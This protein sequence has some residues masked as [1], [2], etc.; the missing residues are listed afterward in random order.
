MSKLAVGAAFAA[1]NYYK[2]KNE[3]D[4]ANRDNKDSKNK[5]EEHEY[6]GWGEDN[7]KLEMC[8]LKE[9]AYHDNP[10]LLEFFKEFDKYGSKIDD[11]DLENLAKEGNKMAEELRKKCEEQEKIRKKLEQMGI[12]FD[13]TYSDRI[14]RI[15]LFDTQEY[16]KGY[17]YSYTDPDSIN[18]F[19]MCNKFNGLVLTEEMLRTPD[20]SGFR[21]RYEKEKT[22]Y[23]NEMEEEKNLTK[24]LESNKR[25]AKFLVFKRKSLEEENARI[26]KRLEEINT[27]RVRTEEEKVRAETFEN[28]TEEQKRDLLEYIQL[29]EQCKKL[30][31]EIEKEICSKMDEIKPSLLTSIYTIRKYE[32]SREKWERTFQLMIE[33]G[34]LTRD[35]L[36]DFIEIIKEIQEKQ[37]KG[38]YKSDFMSKGTKDYDMEK[39]L[40]AIKWIL[41]NVYPSKNE[42]EN[43]E[44]L[45]IEDDTDR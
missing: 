32:N 20:Y 3:K 17:G 18:V 19:E 26:E 10:K 9:L 21:D 12:S 36:T 13:A 11:L 45:E 7:Q 24:K 34:V 38:E 23:E 2:R 25:K 29:V 30:K 4:N 14:M 42:K 28:L 31:Q 40:N 15:P 44:E 37:K 16:E 8:I 22:K 6:L 39:Y 5:N 27:Q 41:E 35:S 33:E 43:S 1:Y